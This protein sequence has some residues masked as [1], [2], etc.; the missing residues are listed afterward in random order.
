MHNSYPKTGQLKIN[1]HH[2]SHKGFIIKL[3]DFPHEPV[4]ITYGDGRVYRGKVNDKTFAPS[5][6]GKVTFLDKSS[7]EGQWLD[8]Y[9]HGF[10]Q[11]SWADGTSYTG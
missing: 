5:G 3:E 4:T 8:G 9:M 10:G 6:K 1:N 7:Y 11:F 2:D